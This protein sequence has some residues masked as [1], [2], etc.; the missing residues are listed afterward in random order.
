MW[1]PFLVDLTESCEEIAVTGRV[2]EAFD[3]TGDV[4]L[5]APLSQVERIWADFT[6]WARKNQLDAA[7]R[8]NHRPGVTILVAVTR[9][10]PRLYELEIFHE[11]YFRGFPLFSAQTLLRATEVDERGWRRLRPGTAAIF[12]L[13]P[14]AI[15]WDGRLKAVGIKRARLLADIAGDVESARSAARTT[16]WIAPAWHNLIDSLA[17]GEWSRRAALRLELSAIATAAA[18]PVRLARRAGSRV[19]KNRC[20]V[21]SAVGRSARRLEESLGSWLEVVARTHPVEPAGWR[22]IGGMEALP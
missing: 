14:N 16:T 7:V 12:K 18:S 6:A 20:A 5:V 19:S 13:V 10:D 21:H 11:R 17:D 22:H 4:D 15:T 9:D 8:C 1:R 2:E 3:G